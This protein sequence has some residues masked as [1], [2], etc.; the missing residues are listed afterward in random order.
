MEIESDKLFRL[1]KALGYNC[2]NSDFQNDKL[3][4]LY[5]NG[6]FKIKI[7]MEKIK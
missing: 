6:T 2:D 1:L 7:E 4:D 5:S 3:T